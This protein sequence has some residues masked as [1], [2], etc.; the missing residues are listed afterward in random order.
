MNGVVGEL[1]VLL[2]TCDLVSGDLVSAGELTPSGALLTR[3]SKDGMFMLEG[4]LE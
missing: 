4:D 3:S 2:V 1:T